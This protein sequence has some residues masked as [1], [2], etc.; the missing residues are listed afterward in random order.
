L[1]SVDTGV[2]NPL[3]GAA[4]SEI[5][6]HSRT[7]HKTQGFGSTPGLGVAMEYFEHLAGEPTTDDVFAGVDTSW[8][9][10][11]DSAPVATAIARAIDAYSP[12]APADSVP[13][14]IEAHRALSALP[15]QVWKT[16]KLEDIERVIAACL[17]LDLESIS[18][19]PSAVPGGD[20]TVEL[21]AIQRSA[22]DVRIALSL[23]TAE[24][25]AGEPTRL[26]P[27]ELIQISR[28]VS[29][30]SAVDTSQPYWLQVPYE[31]GRYQVA[32]AQ[33]IGAPEN[34]PTLPV[35]VLVAV[36]GY[37]LGYSLA[38]TYNYNDPVRGEVKEPFVLTPPA[39]VNLPGSPLIFSSTQ[40]ETIVARVIARSDIV[41]GQ[42]RFGVENGWKVEPATI[43]FD[44]ASGQELSFETTLTP[45]DEANQAVLNAELIIDGKAYSR[46]FERIEYDHIPAQTLFPSAQIRVVLLDVKKEGDRI[47]YIPGAGDAIPEALERIGYAVETLAESDM[48]SET[49]AEYDAVVLGIRALNT[50]LR[51]GYYMP[52]LFEYA[53]E[54]GVV[55]LQ[56][57]TNRSLKTDSFSPY[58]LTLSRERATDETAAMRVLSP[59]HP[60]LNVPNVISSADFDGWVQERGLYFASEWD[61]AFT[62]IL[63]VN[64]RDED[65]SEG[66]L[67]VAR[68][69]DGWFVYSGLSWFRQLPAGV[70]GAY[71]IF[72]N[73]VSLGHTE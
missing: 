33:Q 35:D 21:N 24:A 37:T 52:A 55:I 1:L 61:P 6:A 54:G 36:D 2:Y 22:R 53:S 45:P 25:T 23:P 72:A 65:P 34:R 38:T 11:P 10:V 59:E 15:A 49:L 57:N 70:P 66:S 9:R 8:S 3:L 40:P 14:L 20:V 62:P 68:H 29:L 16:R 60:V 26:P 58:A 73:L 12:Q 18:E 19:H 64:D 30:P 32:D 71:R 4:Y 13:S 28:T 50:N 41:N 17:G 46:G 47:G 51:I 39:M 42:L 67:L 44:A 63:S 5:A 56:Y 7:S 43:T 31:I 48:N 69:G 27:N